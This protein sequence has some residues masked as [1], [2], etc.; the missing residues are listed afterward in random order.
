MWIFNNIKEIISNIVT[1]KQ[2][3]FHPSSVKFTSSA[4]AQKTQTSYSNL[5]YLV[6]SSHVFLRKSAFFKRI[7]KHN[8]EALTCTASVKRTGS[9]SYVTEQTA[10][11]TLPW[12]PSRRSDITFDYIP[13]K[14]DPKKKCKDWNNRLASK[15]KKGLQGSGQKWTSWFDFEDNLLERIK[16]L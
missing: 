2:I 1:K 13:C 3:A 5:T 15:N 8:K 11:L 4:C 16:V 10:A 7:F 9:I 6:S 14:A 12:R